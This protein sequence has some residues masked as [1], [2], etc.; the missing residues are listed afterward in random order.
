MFSGV[1]TLAIRWTNLGLTD[2]RRA[3]PFGMYNANSKVWWRRD[4]GLGLFFSAL[5]PVKGNV[6][7]TAH[8][9]ILDNQCLTLQ[10]LF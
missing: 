9:F 1:I 8:K 7:A 3:V 2:A 5:V 10:I 6:Y 4:N